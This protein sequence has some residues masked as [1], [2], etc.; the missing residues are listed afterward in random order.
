MARKLSQL[1]RE[2]HGMVRK[3]KTESWREFIS[4]ANTSKEVSKIIQILENPPARRM[5]LLRDKDE[6]ILSPSDSL[7]R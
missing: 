5:S 6:N 2:Y 4:K 7:D 3:A 1:K